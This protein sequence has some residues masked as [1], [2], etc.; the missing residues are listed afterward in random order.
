M[1]SLKG[2]LSF[3]SKELIEE[4]ETHGTYMDLHEGTEVLREGQYI[5]MLPIVLS[6]AIKVFTRSEDKELLLYNIEPGE[7]CVMSFMA[8]LKNSASRVF[9]VTEENSTV[10]L[11]PAN[12]L[13]YWVNQYPCFNQL[14]YALYDQRY[15][16]LL[17]TINHLLYNKLDTRIY[18]YL[19]EK[20]KQKQTR[21]V[22]IRHRQIASEL[23]TAREV[24]SRLIKKL[25]QEGKIRQLSHG[26]EILKEVTKVTKI[27]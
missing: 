12:K 21:F 20:G 11:L 7:S 26:I 1:I 22:E 27:R 4:L 10:L 8:G 2:Q 14:F 3:F 19:L 13:Q 16:S 15:S 5:K 25:E 18:S 24:V 9:A 23:G 17:D 6:G